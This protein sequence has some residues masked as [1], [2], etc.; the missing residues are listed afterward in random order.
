MKVTD[1]GNGRQ[2]PKAGSQRHIFPEEQSLLERLTMPKPIAPVRAIAAPRIATPSMAKFATS[3]PVCLAASL[4]MSLIL[5]V[6]AHAE[7]EYPWCAQ[8]TGRNGGGTN[9]GFVTH[10]QCVA[11]VSGAA[12]VCYENP[13][14]GY[15]ST[16]PK[17][18]VSP[19]R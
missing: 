3:L 14:Y 13:R 12:G 4:A 8:Y 15:E 11:T 17:K 16:R 5:P 6:P 9:C 19:P 10:A 18:H 7:I 1:D 2:L